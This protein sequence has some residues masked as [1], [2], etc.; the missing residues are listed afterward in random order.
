MQ[1]HFCLCLGLLQLNT[2]HLTFT[3]KGSGAVLKFVCEFYCFLTID[4]LLKFA[5]D[6]TKSVIFFVGIINVWPL[7]VKSIENYN[8]IGARTHKVGRIFFPQLQS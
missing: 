5:D 6:V 7:T 2:I 4:L 1:S 8:S 3:W